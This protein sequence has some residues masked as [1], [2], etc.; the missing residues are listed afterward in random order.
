MAIQ[1]VGRRFAIMGIGS[2]W[3]SGFVERLSSSRFGH[4]L[5]APVFMVEL[6]VWRGRSRQNRKATYG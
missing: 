1:L 5:E 2:D 3:R 6:A 4:L